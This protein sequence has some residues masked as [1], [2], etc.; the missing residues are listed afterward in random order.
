VH[1]VPSDSALVRGVTL[2]PGSTIF[3]LPSS[4][5]TVRAPCP[6]G[7]MSSPR[8]A[9]RE[10]GTSKGTTS[11]AEV[12]PVV[13]HVGFK[14][15]RERGI[16]RMGRGGFRD[17]CT[18]PVGLIGKEQFLD[19]SFQLQV[20]VLPPGLGEEEDHELPSGP[21]PGE[22]TVGAGVADDPGAC[23]FGPLG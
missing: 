12:G 9:W 13:T 10:S 18:S 8:R 19:D 20:N 4:Q 17:P 7:R 23:R 16:T 1:Q 6:P 14:D 2:L 15:A 5:K 3:T 22:R 11:G 21:G